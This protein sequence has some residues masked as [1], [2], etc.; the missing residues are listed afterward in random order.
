M[1]EG[2]FSRLGWSWG[3]SGCSS[4]PKPSQSSVALSSC[5]QGR[6]KRKT[7][8]TVESSGHEDEMELRCR[9]SVAVETGSRV[10]QG[11]RA[12]YVPEGREE[13]VALRCRAGRAGPRRR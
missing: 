10:T 8:R 13:R 1:L 5:G 3:T 11:I 6:L 9:A 2:V 12:C 4:S 7:Q